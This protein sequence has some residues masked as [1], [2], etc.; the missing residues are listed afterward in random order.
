MI[1]KHMLEVAADYLI[2][3][4]HVWSSSSF[5]FQREAGSSIS[6]LVS[7]CLFGISVGDDLAAQTHDLKLAVC[8]TGGSSVLKETHY[9]FTQCSTVHSHKLSPKKRSYDTSTNM[10]DELPLAVTLCSTAGFFVAVRFDWEEEKS[11]EHSC[12][13]FS[14]QI[15][16]YRTQGPWTYMVKAESHT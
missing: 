12:R 14:E 15:H 9:I 8:R 16:A 10:A 11:N 2:A 5:A 4:H 13:H 6:N 3:K 7:R 1:N